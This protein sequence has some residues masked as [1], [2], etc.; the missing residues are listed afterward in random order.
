MHRY[1]LLFLFLLIAS[2]AH[3]NCTLNTFADSTLKQRL[4]EFQAGDSI[5]LQ[6]QCTEISAGTH[7]ITVDWIKNNSGIIRTDSDHFQILKTLP[8][9]FYF[10]FKLDKPGVL[11]RISSLSEYNTEMLGDWRVIVRIDDRQI[12]VLSFLYY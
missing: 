10:W 1:I 6:I 11:N 9:E 5:H 7:L 3:S 4:E 8:R 2:P 12:G